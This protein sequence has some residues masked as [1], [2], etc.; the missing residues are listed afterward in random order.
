[1]TRQRRVPALISL[2]AL[3]CAIVG[4][5]SSVL[6]DP[7]DLRLISADVH[8]FHVK[9][10]R[11]AEPEAILSDLSRVGVDREAMPVDGSSRLSPAPTVGMGELMSLGSVEY[12]SPLYLHVETHDTVAYTNKVILFLHPDAST[13]PIEARIERLGGVVT[14]ASERVI[15]FVGP[16]R[17]ARRSVFVANDLAKVPGIRSAEAEPTGPLTTS[18]LDQLT[19]HAADQ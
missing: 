18:I 8:R 12:V 11:E 10:L 1:V 9:F 13:G 15:A 3:A 7:D 16:W 2:V 14:Y 4:C 19:T 17:D 5:G 6:V